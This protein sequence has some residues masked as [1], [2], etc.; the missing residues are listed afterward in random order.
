MLILLI[1]PAVDA[2]QYEIHQSINQSV[3][4]SFYYL[5]VVALLIRRFI[6]D[7]LITCNV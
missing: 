2:A 1:N 6:L 7:L 4:V 3:L 5:L